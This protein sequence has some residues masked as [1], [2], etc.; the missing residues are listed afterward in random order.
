M[1]LCRISQRR[2]LKY[3]NISN[4]EVSFI[5]SFIP[6]L[7]LPSP[8]TLFP[9]WWTCVLTLI[10]FT[11]QIQ[12]SYSHC[13][14]SRYAQFFVLH[15]ATKNDTFM[16][17]KTSSVH[18]VLWNLDCLNPSGHRQLSRCLNTRSVKAPPQPQNIFL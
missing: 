9:R 5:V 4:H 17:M 11:D 3:V 8:Q 7:F 6:L 13:H 2:S 16:K 12:P 18:Q 15:E 14:F 1:I 10:P